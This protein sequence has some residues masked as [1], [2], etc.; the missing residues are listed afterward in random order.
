MSLKY[1]IRNSKDTKTYI[2][3]QPTENNRLDDVKTILEDDAKFDVYFNSDDSYKK[4]KE[5]VDRLISK[6]EFLCKGLNPDYIVTSFDNADAVIIIGSSMNV[7]PNG[8]IFGFAL[9]NFDEKHNAIYIDV[10]CSH[11]GMKGVGEILMNEIENINKKL[12]MT[13]IYLKSVKSAISF[14]EKYGFTKHD[15][16]CDD[17]CLMIKSIKSGG[18]KKTTKKQ[19][20]KKRGKKTLT[21]KKKTAKKHRK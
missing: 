18:K 1:N 6:S 15:K 11:I 10:I 19:E 2:Y 9:I 4:V 21:K 8:N 16:S 20:S 13:D 5:Y 7:L 3:F 17:M 14:Y 12:S